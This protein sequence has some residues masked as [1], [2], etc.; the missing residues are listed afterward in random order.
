MNMHAK[1]T[2]SGEERYR[3]G[4]MEYKKMGYWKPDYVPSDTDVIALFRVTPQDGVDLIR[5]RPPLP[6]NRRP[7]HGRWCGPTALRLPRNTGRNATVSKQCRIARPV[8][9]L[10]RLRSRPVRKRLDRQLSAS[11]IGNVFGFGPLK[12]LRLEDMRSPVAYVKTFQGRPPVS[13]SNASA[14]T[15]SGDR[16]SVRRSSRSSI[17][18]P[19]LRTRRVRSAQG[20]ARFHQ[21]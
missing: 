1:A 15:S 2:T 16:C 6:A 8:F 4:V 7:R 11:I 12:A 9:R 20:R 3:S 17:V 10:Y 13:W 18:R 19:Q 14:S 5:R 21:G